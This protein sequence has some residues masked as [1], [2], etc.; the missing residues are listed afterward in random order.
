MINLLDPIPFKE[1]EKEDA[2]SQHDNGKPSE[3]QGS[4][5]FE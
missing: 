1:P 5:G 3:R 2:G 4:L